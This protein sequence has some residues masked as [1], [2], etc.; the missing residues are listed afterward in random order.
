MSPVI[1]LLQRTVYAPS[2]LAWYPITQDTASKRRQTLSVPRIPAR[3]SPHALESP[4]FRPERLFQC[5]PPLC[6]NN[7]PRP[8]A[9]QHSRL[10]AGSLAARRISAGPDVPSQTPIPGSFHP[11]ALPPPRPRPHALPSAPPLPR[12]VWRDPPPR[13]RRHP[14]PSPA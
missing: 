12:P 7:L 10:G 11:K 1:S 9:N 4:F 13:P 6:S 5:R 14:S 8:V 3:P 2:S